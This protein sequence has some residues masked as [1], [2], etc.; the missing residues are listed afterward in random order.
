[1]VKYKRMESLLRLKTIESFK[2]LYLICKIMYLIGFKYVMTI[3][4]KLSNY[5]DYLKFE[6]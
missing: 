1:M 5:S 3:N 6:I 4:H 2:S